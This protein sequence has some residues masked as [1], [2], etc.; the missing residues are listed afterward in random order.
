MGGLNIP[1]MFTEQTAKH[2]HTLLKF[3]G[4]VGD[5]TGGLIQ[6]TEEAFRLEAGFTGPLSK[7][8]EKVYSYVTPTWIS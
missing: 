4:D 2:I 3:G 6:A 5:M 7:F 8:P 1:N